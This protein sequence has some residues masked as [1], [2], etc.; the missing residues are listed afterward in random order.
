MWNLKKDL[1]TQMIK[2]KSVDNLIDIKNPNPILYLIPSS[3]NLHHHLTRRNKCDPALQ[4][5]PLRLFQSR[6]QC[7]LWANPV[8]A[9]DSFLSQL[10]RDKS[11]YTLLIFCQ[12]L[13]PSICLIHMRVFRW[14]R[15]IWADSAAP[16]LQCLSG[17]L[18]TFTPFPCS[19]PPDLRNQILST[20]K[21][22]PHNLLPD[23]SNFIFFEI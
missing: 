23:K 17:M 9:L 19:F 7:P 18:F 5:Q 13:H 15:G 21:K 8:S 10:L 3:N 16:S 4:Q 1:E 2:K 14:S 6:V 20:C 12:H 11:V 22:E